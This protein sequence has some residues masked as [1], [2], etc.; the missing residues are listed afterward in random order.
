M[1]NLSSIPNNKETKTEQ[2]D[3]HYNDT[4]TYSKNIIYSKGF[5]IETINETGYVEIKFL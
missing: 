5:I 3:K 1:K 4:L 2:R